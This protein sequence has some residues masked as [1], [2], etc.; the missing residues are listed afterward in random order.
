MAREVKGINWTYL[1]DA[2]PAFLTITIMPFTYSI[3]DGMIAGIMS[4]ILINLIVW[5]IEKASGGR[6]KPADKSTKDPWT[7]KI[8]GGF[9]PPY[10]QRIIA[11]K[12]DFWRDYEV[13]QGQNVAAEGKRDSDEAYHSINIDNPEKV[14]VNS[15][16]PVEVA[17]GE[18]TA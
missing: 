12:K 1:G 17:H 6:I 10:L 18:K 13:D 7:Y 15:P 14:D 11:G 2:I 9:F 3:A 5:I 8:P 16:R 4:Y